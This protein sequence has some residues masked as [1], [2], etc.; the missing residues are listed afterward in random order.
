MPD[1]QVFSLDRIV[2]Q[3]DSR[4]HWAR[5]TVSYAFATREPLDGFPSGEDSGLTSF[6]A[7]QRIAATLALELWQD[8]IQVDFV[9]NTESNANILFVNYDEAGQAYAYF[10]VIGDVFI[11]P[12]QSSNLQLDPGGYGLLT[13]IHEI[14]HSL[15]LNH[16][17]D[18][19]ASRGGLLNYRDQAEYQQ[20][21]HQYSVMY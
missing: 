13:L 3:L 11:N 9:L 14:G 2:D 10:P 6:N 17:G 15:G 8:L 5:Q 7:N 12:Q 16:P 4:N 21:L 18:Y 20:D 1:K 19:D